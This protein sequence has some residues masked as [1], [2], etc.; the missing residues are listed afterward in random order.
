M[1]RSEAAF[2]LLALYNELLMTTLVRKE[3]LAAIGIAIDE[4]NKKEADGCAQC[5]FRYKGEGQMPCIKCKRNY[6]DYWRTRKLIMNNN[7]GEL[8]ERYAEFIEFEE[9]EEE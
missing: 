7:T 3:A 4:L 6:K 5:G 2:E 9:E 8:T 1:N